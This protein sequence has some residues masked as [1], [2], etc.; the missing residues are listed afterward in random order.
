MDRIESLWFLLLESKKRGGMKKSPPYA[1]LKISSAI[2][3]SKNLLYHD[4]SNPKSKDM[5]QANHF[6]CIMSLSFDN[7]LRTIID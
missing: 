4:F 2:K 7:M 1:F 5:N 6:S 3:S